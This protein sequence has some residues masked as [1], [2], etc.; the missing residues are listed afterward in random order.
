MSIAFT[1]YPRRE[2]MSR[3]H[4]VRSADLVRDKAQQL[5][6]LCME[7]VL[8]LYRLT[9]S[10]RRPP[11]NVPVRNRLGL[12]SRRQ[13]VHMTAQTRVSYIVPQCRVAK[14]RELITNL[15]GHSSSMRVDRLGGILFSPTPKPSQPK[16]MTD[17]D[18]LGTSVI[19]LQ[20]R[21][22]TDAQNGRFRSRTSCEVYQVSRVI[23][24][25]GYLAG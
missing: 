3:Q 25:G 5:I 15:Q 19:V 18:R 1:R 24:S 14:L 17:K 4:D 2:K 10:R 23:R 9:C 20:L 11:D 7:L 6:T 16:E 21:A 8:G 12:D 22:P 13:P